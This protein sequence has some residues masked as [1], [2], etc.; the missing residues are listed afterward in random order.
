MEAPLGAW[1][2]YSGALEAHPGALEV[3]P[4]VVGA[5]PV[6]VKA[7]LNQ[8]ELQGSLV[9]QSWRY[10]PPAYRSRRFHNILGPSNQD[11]I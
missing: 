5:Q 9:G 1:E 3:R 11:L 10:I 2:A 6:A 4:G 8:K 7:P